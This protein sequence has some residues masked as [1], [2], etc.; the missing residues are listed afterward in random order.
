MKGI[1]SCQTFV[2]S[3]LLATC[4]LIAQGAIDSQDSSAT[5][6]T[7]CY[8]VKLG[9]W[10]PWGLGEDSQFVTPP[11]RVELLKKRGTDGWEK[12]HF[13]VR[14]LLN[15][16]GRRGPS[17]WDVQSDTHIKLVWTDGFTGV[18]LNLKKDQDAL[19]GWAHPHFDSFHLI[20]HVARVK[21]QR[22]LCTSP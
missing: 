11:S 7:G 4:P 19:Q 22:I 15:T 13:L 10:W 9:R 1:Y 6:L 18:T 14:V 3:I 12:D 2:L 21:M 20:T 5:K 17:F 8:Q 16:P